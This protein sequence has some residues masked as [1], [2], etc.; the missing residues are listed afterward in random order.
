MRNVKEGNMVLHIDPNHRGLWQLGRVTE[1][2]PGQDGLVRSV[3]IRTPHTSVV[4]PVTK[5]SLLEG[6]QLVQ[7]CS[8]L[9]VYLLEGMADSVT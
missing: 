1:T 9:G 8:I 4:R 2:F 5:L 6:A 3:R 7:V